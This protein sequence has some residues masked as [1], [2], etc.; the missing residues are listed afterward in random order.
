MLIEVTDEDISNG[1]H[2]GC[3]CPIA[4][5]LARIIPPGTFW[6]CRKKVFFGDYS[7][8]IFWDGTSNGNPI[9]LPVAAV[10][11]TEVH[12]GTVDR[13]RPFAFELPEPSHAKS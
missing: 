8:G 10:R 2:K 13:A 5:A 11:F 12:D 9:D 7:Q 3:D 1:G 4:L 6:V